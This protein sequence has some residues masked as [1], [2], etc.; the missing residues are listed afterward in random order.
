MSLPRLRSPCARAMGLVLLCALSGAA[1]AQA[2]EVSPATRAAQVDL[3]D[4]ATL[5]PD[6]VADMRYAGAHNFTGA[7]VPGYAAPVCLL[8]SPAARALAAVQ[9]DLRAQ[10]LRLKLL[11]CYRPVRAVERFVQWARDLADQRTKPEFYP[12][13]DKAALLGDYIA[14]TSGHSRGATVD[15]TL[16]RCEGGRC[17]ELDMGTPFDFFDTRANTD[18]PLAGPTQRQHRQQ[19]VAAMARHGF[20]NYPMEWWHFT[21]RPEPTPNTAYDVPV[22]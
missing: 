7:P 9:E 18:S 16:L 6:V 15:L 14:E 8:L 19:L 5:A 12:N 21:Y 4:V 11:D 22:E 17:E 10:N 3:I 20:A 13:L 2:V 1:G